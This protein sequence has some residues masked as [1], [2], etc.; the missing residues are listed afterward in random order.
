M[1]ELS[2]FVWIHRCWTVGPWMADNNTAGCIVKHNEWVV[3]WMEQRAGRREGASRRR[4]NGLFSLFLW[5]K[6]SLNCQC[7]GDGSTYWKQIIGC[8]ELIS[9][10]GC[11]CAASLGG[12]EGLVRLPGALNTDR[13][14]NVGTSLFRSFDWRR[15]GMKLENC[16]SITFIDAGDDCSNRVGIWL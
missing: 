2:P 12:S 6:D 10:S 8:L 3:H 1:G 15:I 7:F 4:A 11:Y 9:G 14:S 16:I 5:S 13:I